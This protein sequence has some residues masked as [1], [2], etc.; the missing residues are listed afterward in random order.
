MLRLNKMLLPIVLIA[1][2]TQT[3]AATLGED[4]SILASSLPIVMNGNDA[5]KTHHELQK[6]KAAAEDAKKS[7]PPKLS[8]QSPDSDQMKGFRTG[9]DSLIAQIDIVDGYAQTNQL[10]LAKSEAVKLRTI[11][12][13]N[14]SLY[15]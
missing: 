6:M 15:N 10:E 5:V 11:A 1:V 2:T 8:G 9:L 14:H 13:K 3:N 7:T 12:Q 4:M